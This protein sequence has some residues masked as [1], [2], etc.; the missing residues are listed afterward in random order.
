MTRMRLSAAGNVSADAMRAWCSEF[1]SPSNVSTAA[2]GPSRVC[3]PSKQL[4]AWV[5]PAPTRKQKTG[6]GVKE[7]GG[8]Q[9]SFTADRAP[10]VVSETKK[11]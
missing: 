3:C 5:E 8:D 11:R 7:C 4:P 9:C 10:V 2:A 6:W 1:A